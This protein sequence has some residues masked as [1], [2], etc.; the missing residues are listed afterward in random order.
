MSRGQ[1]HRRWSAPAQ[2][3]RGILES[4]RDERRNFQPRA[5]VEFPVRQEVAQV[6]WAMPSNGESLDGDVVT[7]LISQ[8]AEGR[9]AL[10][11]GDSARPQLLDGF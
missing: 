5:V 10:R 9:L 4:S 7:P 6:G 1:G 11:I 3:V 2:K 8:A